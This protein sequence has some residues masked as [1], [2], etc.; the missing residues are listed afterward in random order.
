MLDAD[1]DMSGV[2]AHRGAC[3][4]EHRAGYT[5]YVV[6]DAARVLAR[7]PEANAAIGG[8]VVPRL[9]RYERVTAKVAFDQHIG[10]VR[11][12]V[13]G[14]LP[15]ADRTT[16]DQIQRRIRYYKTADPQSAPE[17]AGI[18]LLHRLPAPVAAVAFRAAVGSL[19]RRQHV[20][21]TFSVSS[22]GHR[23]VAGFYPLGGTAISFGLGRVRDVPV[24]RDR[25]VVPGR[26]MR[27]GLVFDHRVI[28]GALA[29]DILHDVKIRLEAWNAPKRTA[30]TADPRLTQ[31][32]TTPAPAGAAARS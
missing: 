8:R 4:S 32:A 15:D 17:H 3:A 20:M 11:A 1:V 6:H 22:L 31:A 5:A 29:A 18:R 23:A 16:L 12:V 26:V 30:S 10:D 9:A 25:Q 28:D 14:L 19:R 21:G 2:A 24:V 7:H 27:L 13:S